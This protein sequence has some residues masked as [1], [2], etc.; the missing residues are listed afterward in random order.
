MRGALVGKSQT[1][2]AEDFAPETPLHSP[3]YIISFAVAALL[4]KRRTSGTFMYP[5]RKIARAAPR[6]CKN[7]FASAP[8]PLG[9]EIT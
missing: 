6:L 2:G 9:L 1:R 5:R 3:Q 8:Q 4:D 7:F